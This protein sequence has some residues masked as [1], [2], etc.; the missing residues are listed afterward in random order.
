MLDNQISLER[1]PYLIYVI[2]FVEMVRFYLLKLFSWHLSVKM[3]G[4]VEILSAMIYTEIAV[5]D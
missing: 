3:A 4:S 1:S 5:I 2:Y